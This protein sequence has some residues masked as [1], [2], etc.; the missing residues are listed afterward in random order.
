MPAATSFLFMVSMDVDADKE[1]LF[2]EVYDTEHVPYLLEVQGVRAV[3]RFKA[4]PFSFAMAGDIKE[5]PAA[6]PAYTAMYEI[7]SP[8]VLTSAAWAEAI[9]RGRWASEVR[10]YTHNRSHGLYKK[11]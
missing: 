11:R 9:E 8:D 2:N 7:D 4:Q 10:P 5:M 3:T 6:S 1:D